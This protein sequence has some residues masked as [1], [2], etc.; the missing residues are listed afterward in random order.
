[1]SNWHSASDEKDLPELDEAV[2]ACNGD[3]M[4]FGCRTQAPEDWEDNDVPGG[5]LW[6]VTDEPDWSSEKHR[7]TSFV[8]DIEPDCEPTHWHRLPEPED[9]KAMR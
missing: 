9:G 4:W 1:M 3:R 6:A 7:W 5:W 8:A 2:V